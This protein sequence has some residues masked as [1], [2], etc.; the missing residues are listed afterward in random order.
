MALRLAWLHQ[1]RR[2]RAEMAKNGLRSPKRRKRGKSTPSDAGLK[3]PALRPNLRD[4]NVALRLRPLAQHPALATRLK[5]TK[6]ILIA[7][8]MELTDDYLKV[9][10]ALRDLLAIYDRGGHDGYGWTATEILRLA[11]IRKLAK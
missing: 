11:E 1:T 5:P 7:S 6:A 2:E 8:C 9:H 3:S 4:V 10:T